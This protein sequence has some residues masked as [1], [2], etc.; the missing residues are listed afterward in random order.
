MSKFC[1]NCGAEL[2]E[3]AE[4]CLTCGA[5]NEIKHSVNQN[6][7]QT[8]TWSIVASIIFSLI[9][10]YIYNV[11]VGMLAAGGA[12]FFG[13]K[14]YNTGDSYKVIGIVLNIAAVI[15]FLYNMSFY[16]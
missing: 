11:D 7:Q 15:M 10:L 5:L 4:V 2:N 13:L 12:L 14:V 3:G 16:F 9:S 6:I 8:P 1:T